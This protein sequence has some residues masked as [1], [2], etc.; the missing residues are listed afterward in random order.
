MF[1]SLCEDDAYKDLVPKLLS[2]NPSGH[3]KGQKLAV[4]IQYFIMEQRFNSWI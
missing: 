1:Y 4:V 3:Q 2:K